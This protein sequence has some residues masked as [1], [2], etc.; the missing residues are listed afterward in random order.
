MTASELRQKF[1]DFF[2]EKGHTVIPSASLVPENDPSV[3]FTTAGMHPLVPYLLGEKHPGGS[4]LTDVQKC[5]R[6]DDI[7]EV[8]DKFHHTFFEMLGNWSLGDYFKKEAVEWSYEFLTSRE[9]LGLSKERLAVSVFEG[10]KDAPFDEEVYGIWLELGIVPSRIAKLPKKDNWWGPAGLTGPCGPDTE[11]FYWTG[12]SDVPEKFDPSDN[13]WV[14]IWNDVFMQYN[15]TVDSRFE[16]LSQKNVDTGMGL[17]RALAVVDGFDDDYRTELF[18]PIIKK[19]EEIS[20]KNYEESTKEFRI[21]AD[22]IKAAVFAIADGVSP[23]NK[24]R[25]YIVRRLIRRAIVKAR[26]LGITNNFTSDLAEPVFETYAGVYSFSL[27]EVISELQKEE[28]KFR[29][30]LEEG[31]KLIASYKQI[32][33]K[34]LFDLYQSFG[35]PVEI[36]LEEAKNCSAVIEGETMKQFNDLLRAHQELSRTASAGMFKGGLS[37]ASDVV[38]KYHTA[39]HLLNAALRKVL[40]DHVYQKGSNI[41]AERLR[42]DFSHPDK[43]TPEQISA[44]ESLVNDQISAN[45]SVNR[46][47][48]TMEDAQSSGAIGVFESKYGEKV[49]VYT[50]GQ[51]IDDYFSKEICGGPHASRTGELGRFKI[52][53]EEA[54]SAGVRRIKA[55]LE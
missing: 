53:K 26:G 38:T 37:D 12:G 24:D 6:T 29:K 33:G 19:I 20:G 4:R 31:L 30:T 39:T 48:M 43:M 15:K 42:F 8:G 46:E 40:G 14:E 25:G 21:I 3:L 52:I 28:T 1:I 47:E 54:S 45:L 16:P 18:L 32:D 11:M 2:K 50:I 5:I 13:N 27:Q 7:D 22:H 55:V 51:A 35:L 36:S 49:K 41:T 17:E 44:V 23:S 10:D 34:V 9:W